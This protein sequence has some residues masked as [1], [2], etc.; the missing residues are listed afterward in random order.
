MLTPLEGE[1]RLLLQSRIRL[2]IATTDS[3]ICREMPSRVERS[4]ASGKT[5]ALP[6]QTI[7]LYFSFAYNMYTTTTSCWCFN[8]T[9]VVVACINYNC[10]PGLAEEDSGLGAC[11]SLLTYRNDTIMFIF[12]TMRYAGRLY[13]SRQAGWNFFGIC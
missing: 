10:S 2:V 11:P 5:K 12:V 9:V 8:Y 4:T 6:M 3:S 13:T 7:L 1:V